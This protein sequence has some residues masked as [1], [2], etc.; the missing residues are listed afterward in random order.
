MVKQKLYLRRLSSKKG[1]QLKI[2]W[3]KLVFDKNLIKISKFLLIG[4]KN[5]WLDMIGLYMIGLEMIG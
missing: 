1:K 2:I 4:L 5:I 3:N